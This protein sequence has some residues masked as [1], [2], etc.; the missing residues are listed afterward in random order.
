LTVSKSGT[1]SGAVSSADSNINCGSTCSATYS[2]ATN[3]TLT[4]APVSGSTF[5]GWIG[6]C[7]GTGTCAVSMN[8]AQSVTATFNLAPFVAVT[9][10]VTNGIITTPTA[11]VAI[12]VSFNAGDRNTPQSVFVT[13]WAPLNTLSTT[14][15]A[16]I[17]SY[18]TRQV[19]PLGASTTTTFVLMQETS[20]SGWQPVVNGQLIP[21]VSGVL[22]S[23]SAAISILNGTNTSTILGSQFCVGYGTSTSDMTA[24]G[25]MQLIATVPNPNATKSNTGSC[26]VALPISDARV[27]AF[28]VANYANF[29]AGTVT[30]GQYQQYD[31]RLYSATQNYLAVDASGAVWI[32]GPVFNPANAPIRVGPV[33]NFR[34]VITTWE[35]AQ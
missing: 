7:T 27:F 31:Y 15:Q 25:R 35:G 34:S 33:E 17:A 10:G 16:R 6:A 11:T 22:G 14:Q 30:A 20:L 32:M 5:A 9:T 21:Y 28:A 12:T 1:G 29:F 13:A 4:A 8:A 2:S 19:K 24:A 3:V 26:N 23:Q 18:T